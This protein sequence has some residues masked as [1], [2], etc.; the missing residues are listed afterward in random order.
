MVEDY[1]LKEWIKVYSELSPAGEQLFKYCPVPIPALG[2]ELALKM[3]HEVILHAV[4]VG[5]GVV[6]VKQE[7]NFIG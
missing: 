5:Q 1:G 2:S 3:V 7:H 4:V 6:H